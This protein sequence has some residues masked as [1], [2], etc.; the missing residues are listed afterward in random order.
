MQQLAQRLPPR[1]SQ[2]LVS[3]LPR[4]LA[5]PELALPPPRP[6]VRQR[7]LPPLPVPQRLEQLLRPL[8]LPV[9]LAP[10]PLVLPVLALASTLVP[11]AVVAQ[12]LAPRPQPVLALPQR[13]E[14]LAL[15]VLLQEQRQPEPL[16]PQQQ[17]LMAPQ[18]LQPVPL[19]VLERA[20]QLQQQRVLAF[21]P[22][23]IVGPQQRA[24]LQPERGPVQRLAPPPALPQA[25]QLA[26][27]LAQLQLPVVLVRPQAT[28]LQQLEQKLVLV[29]RAQKV[30]LPSQPVR[31]LAVRVLHRRQPVVVAQLPLPM[32]AA[33]VPVP[34][35]R[36]QRLSPC[37]IAS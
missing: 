36:R 24:A 21:P 18:R 26:P 16:P 14:P 15:P 7:V 12:L 22:S 9:P 31:T 8:L 13:M 23:S 37:L 1:V 32:L 17:Q 3:Q 35:E 28:A 19:P 20:L 2:L 10:P 33:V 34:L 6:L 4:V 29:L 27:P 25:Q 11:V 30:E 5:L